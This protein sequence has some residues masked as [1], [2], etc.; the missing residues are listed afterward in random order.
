MCAAFA[1]T[2]NPPCERSAHSVSCGMLKKT[3]EQGL[4]IDRTGHPVDKPQISRTGLFWARTL[5]IVSLIIILQTIISAILQVR[6]LAT[7]AMEAQAEVVRVEGRNISCGK[8]GRRDCTKF[9]ALLR[10][11]TQ[12]A[13]GPYEGWISA[14]QVRGHDRP[15]SGADLRVGQTVQVI[16][17][18]AS[19]DKFKETDPVSL[20]TGSLISLLIGTGM[21]AWSRNIR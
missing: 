10:Y 1:S 16:Y 8:R 14:G 7:V 11:H 2:V 4:S 15:I 6:W 19:P 18:P 17:D 13:G 12:S 5:L 3:V 20:W 21:L 9:S